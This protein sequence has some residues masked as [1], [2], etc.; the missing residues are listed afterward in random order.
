MASSS[1]RLSNS[2]VVGS[3]LGVDVNAGSLG[4]MVE[5]TTS[6]N[7]SLV[8]PTT[9]DKY[10]YI[11][12][13]KTN[14]TINVTLPDS[15]NVAVGWRA[16]LILNSSANTGVINLLNAASSFI[17][18]ISANFAESGVEVCLVNTTSTPYKL[19]YY[20]GNSNSTT[21]RLTIYTRIGTEIVPLIKPLSAMRF[22]SYSS[23][24]IGTLNANLVG[25]VTVPWE[26]GTTGRYVDNN[27]FDTT[28]NTNITPNYPS[29]NV[30][31]F[32]CVYVN[33]SGGATSVTIARLSLNGTGTIISQQV[34]LGTISNTAT[35]V[36]NI[37]GYFVS[38][39]PNF[40]QLQVGKTVL[41]S[42]SNIIDRT[43]TY[44]IAEYI[45]T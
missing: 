38:T 40:V 16:R 2:R 45:S 7:F 43:S 3:G 24:S 36:I 39:S 44:I 25:T 14:S 33:A 15:T 21:S 4:S 23:N 32:A 17:G 19:N 1:F 8:P 18:T 5:I 30:K 29:F 13:I 42:G 6:S 28:I 10:Y 11:Y 22:F 37:T 12:L 26:V 9:F 27:Y 35:Q 41:S 20:Y 34:N 31:I